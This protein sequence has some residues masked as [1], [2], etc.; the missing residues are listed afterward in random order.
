MENER[1]AKTWMI[2]AGVA[3][4]GAGLIGFLGSNPIASSSPD[5]LF[6]VNA[7]HN[8]VHL[9][10]GLVA[11]AIGLGTRGIQL[12]NATIGFGVVYALVAVVSIID[13]TMF[14]LFSDAPVNAADHILHVGLA[15]VSIALGY[16]ARERTATSPRM[17]RSR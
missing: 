14:G 12:A 3:L 11:L 10:T 8:V 15:I 5:A 2:I 4:L 9:L 16:M 6:R 13:P 17:A 7:A 1:I